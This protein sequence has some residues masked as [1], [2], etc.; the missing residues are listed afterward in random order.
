MPGPVDPKAPVPAADN[1]SAG[2]EHHDTVLLTDRPEGSASP[3]ALSLPP[4]AAAALSQRYDILGQA[5]NGAMGHVYK[6]RD[7]ETGETLALKLLKPEIASDQIMME[8]FKNELLLARKI[9]HKNVCR[10]YEFNRVGGV[11][12]TSMEYVEGESLRTVLRRSA[13]YPLRKGLDLALQ[14]CAG[15]KEAHAQGIVHRDLKP[16][17]IMIDAQGN[18]KI[19]DFG[20]ARS[21]EA[22][23]QLT[24]SMTGTPAYMA[25]EQV[26]GKPVDFRADL[27]AL[28]LIL[29][30]VFTGTPAFKADNAVTLA[31]K[32]VRETPPQPHEVRPDIPVLIEQAIMKCLEKEPFKRFQSVGDLET[33]LRAKPAA[34]AM[35]PAA[36]TRPAYGFQPS[37][38]VQ[39]AR[40]IPAQP[41]ASEGKKFD[42]FK[43]QQP[44]IPGVA[45]PKA[46]PEP[47]AEAERAPEHAPAK[48][49][50]ASRWPWKLIGAA[51]AVALVAACGFFYWRRG[52]SPAPQ[53]AVSEPS[54]EAAPAAANES[55][56]AKKLPV[57][58]GPI[59]RT[60]E[61]AEVWSS[62]R[63]V[64]HNTLTS[65]SVPAMVVHLPHGE[66]WAFSL[67]EPYG[68]CELEYV[69]DLERLASEYAF[70][71]D[72]P[73]VA[74][75]CKHT[76]Y[77]LTRYG[78]GATNG[79][80]VRG[81]IVQG[82]GIRPPIAIEIGVRG[83]E[84]IAERIE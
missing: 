68:T 1:A 2:A 19:M 72:H 41:G 73:M 44:A 52:A 6:V 48:D 84:I 32:Q 79:G 11:A 46:E 4:A 60:D 15:L 13:G 81:E 57:G 30:E 66:Y 18:V 69:T 82:P 51:A 70:R 34:P 62:K 78:S 12:Y 58:P 47:G 21:M 26:S 42:P 10:V 40:A 43:P 45:P 20:I 38:P 29:Y 37:Q 27:Y 80:L 16:E 5:G 53:E 36:P 17:N 3:A 22:T 65:E 77:D 33:A 24:G 49:V 25:P 14:I 76:V 7:R 74:N 35:S 56:S 9:T 67:R 71:A 64:F 23:T 54:G 8:R 59:A 50:S 63:F 61:L 75:P 55:E 28:G 31:F 39:P 83:K